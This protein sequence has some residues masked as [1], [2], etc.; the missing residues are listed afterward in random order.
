M[1]AIVILCLISLE[2]YLVYSR[3]V[4]I[5]IA[6]NN[7]DRFELEIPYETNV[8]ENWDENSIENPEEL[9]EYIEGDMLFPNDIAR[10][11]LKAEWT[12]WPNAEIPFEIKGIFSKIFLF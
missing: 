11:G 5:D 9:G 4:E 10:N 8:V 1:N 2:H 3:S 12:R 7:E 6:I